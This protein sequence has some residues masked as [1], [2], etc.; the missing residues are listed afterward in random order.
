MTDI[1]VIDQFLAH[2]KEEAITWH[3]E[4]FLAYRVL[5]DEKTRLM[6]EYG[7]HTTRPN[8]VIA[9]DYQEAH[10]NVKSFFARMGKGMEITIINMSYIFNQHK[11]N[12]AKKSV[13][14]FLD[15][16][17]DREVERKEKQLMYRVKAKAGNIVDAS[18]LYIANDLNI[19]GRV[20]GDKETVSVRTI[21]A[22]G[23]HIQC[24]HY[25][26]LVKIIK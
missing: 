24:L 15:E 23:Y 16:M 9:E 11:V 12:P 14:V 18:G 13:E 3:M 26:I 20:I 22:G 1:P 5:F 19:N 17:M 25:R 8:Q 21:L 4:K 6:D 10:D 2:W 7:Y